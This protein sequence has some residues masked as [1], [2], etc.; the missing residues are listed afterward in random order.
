MAFLFLTNQR[1]RF[2]SFQPSLR[3]VYQPSESRHSD[4][5]LVNSCPTVEREL[6]LMCPMIRSMTDQIAFNRRRPIIMYKSNPHMDLAPSQKADFSE[7]QTN[8]FHA[9][10]ILKSREQLRWAKSEHSDLIGFLRDLRRTVDKLR[11]PKTPI[12]C[13]IINNSESS[14][15]PREGI[16]PPRAAPV[17]ARSKFSVEE[18]SK[19][20]DAVM[21]LG[22][23]KWGAVAR[24]VG[25]RNA[26]QCRE[27]WRNYVNPNLVPSNPWTDEEDAILV[28][29]LLE[30][31]GRWMAIHQLFPS[32]SVHDLKNR[33]RML[34][35]RN[36]SFRRPK[37]TETL[38]ESADPDSLLNVGPPA[39][40]EDPF[41][42]LDKLKP[43]FEREFAFEISSTWS[44]SWT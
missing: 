37:L 10:R 14:M 40:E 35:R 11:I 29:L 8:R 32:R 36:A 39:D 23:A 5:V 22:T 24:D 20:L 21:R 26:R 41:P 12:A 38:P 16:S 3:V 42:F 9:D 19:L 4:E 28:S 33:C 15:N 17:R 1:G 2:R 43:E 6:Q 18:D 31:G 44:P 25:N 13:E 30:M 7:I 34:Y 27:R